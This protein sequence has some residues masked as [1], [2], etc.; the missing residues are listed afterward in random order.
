MNNGDVINIINSNLN[1]DLN[2]N[3]FTAEEFTSIINAQSSLLFAKKLGLPEE[4]RPNMPV[5]RMGAG[6]SRKVD[7][8]LRPFLN[9]DSV[10]VVGGLLDLT[11]KDIGYLLSIDP[12]TISG[13]SVDILFPDEYADRVGSAVVSPTEDDPIAKWISNTKLI[14]APSTITQ[15]TVTYYKNPTE[16]EVVFTTDST[17]LLQ[18]YDATASTESGWGT[19]ALTEIA[20]MSLR[21][22]GVNIEKQD[23]VVHGDNL[24]KN[25]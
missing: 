8:D 25:E 17:T 23:A 13:R 21:D 9:T 19:D 1:R 3:A 14:V 4:Y 6:I 5:G 16:S 18:T 2:G 15:V 11:G 7:E 24:T 12:S 20:Y 10:V 22:A